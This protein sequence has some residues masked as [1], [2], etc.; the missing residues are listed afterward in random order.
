M[1]SESC[2]RE[3]VVSKTSPSLP[4]SANAPSL[5]PPP[6]PLRENT[7]L[8]PLARVSLVLSADILLF[9]SP[10][11]SFRH[12]QS[13]LPL[14]SFKSCSLFLSIQVRSFPPLLPSHFLFS[15]FLFP[16]PSSSYLLSLRSSS[17][18]CLT[19]FYPWPA[20]SE[21][22]RLSKNSSSER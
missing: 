13:S 18:S 10:S 8:F 16:T 4:L 19:F 9:L 15:L 14:F 5:H 12:E 7:V 1:S 20:A 6:Y 2:R 3:Q 11:F 17:F 22:V 21:S